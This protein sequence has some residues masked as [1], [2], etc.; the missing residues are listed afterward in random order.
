[1]TVAELRD[2]MS[3]DEF[4]RWAV[5]QGRKAQREQLAMAKAKR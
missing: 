1:M 4:A 2:R 3:G 5:Y